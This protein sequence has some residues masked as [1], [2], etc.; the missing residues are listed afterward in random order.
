VLQRL[1]RGA[2][3][4][5]L[6]WID[7]TGRIFRHF[8]VE[9][10]VSRE[11]IRREMM[12]DVYRVRQFPKN[13][14]SVAVDIGAYVGHFSS[15]VKALHPRCRVV[16]FEPCRHNLDR[17]KRNT[18][19]RDIEIVE[20]A[21]GDGSILY[22]QNV[23]PARPGVDLAGH[24]IMFTATGNGR[25]EV[26]SAPLEDLLDGVD[27]SGNYCLKID[28][29][30]GE[31]VLL[32]NPRA[33]AIVRGAAHFGMEVHCS[34]EGNVKGERFLALDLP[35]AEDWTRWL[36]QFSKTHRIEWAEDKLPIRGTVV[37][38]RRS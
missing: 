15:F 6:N 2:N 26:Q 10:S 34:F 28:C 22:E 30:G 5:F 20:K 7:E 29:E 33:E 35:V 27:L 9:S 19:G 31:R 24:S 17:L 13:F 11:L 1:K 18:A 38:T 36:Q 25:K 14:F 23:E 4:L 32:E 21:L 12:D 37:M 3:E 16:A 8:D